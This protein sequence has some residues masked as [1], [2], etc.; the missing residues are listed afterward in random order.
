MPTIGDIIRPFWLLGLNEITGAQPKGIGGWICDENYQIYDPI[1]VSSFVLH[2]PNGEPLLEAYAADINRLSAA[3]F[4]TL[5]SLSRSLTFPKST[6]W[7]VIKTYYAAFFAAHA[8]LRMLGISGSHLEREQINSITR[9]ARLYSNPPAKPMAG[10]MYRLTFNTS[11]NLFEG[12]QLKAVVGPHDAFWQTFHQRVNELSTQVLTI[13][14]SSTANRQLVSTKLSDLASNLCFA[15]SGTGRW[16]ST[17][18]NAVNYSQRHATWYPYAGQNAYYEQLFEKSSEWKMDPL[19][20]DL[21][22]HDG[23][24][25][26][27]FQVSCNFIIGLLRDSITEMAFRCSVGKSFHTYGSLAFLNLLAQKKQNSTVK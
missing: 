9:V 17:V 1:T 21:T 23:K 4:E 22:A 19:D 24:E 25:L 12:A 16:L 20:L 26:R 27:R 2:V 15:S 11:L 6:A 14:V 8:F 7:L 5:S 10:G 13:G 18:R 3:S